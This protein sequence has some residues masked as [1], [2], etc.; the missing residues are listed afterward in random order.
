MFYF[1]LIQTATD[2]VQENFHLRLG[3]NE[4]IEYKRSCSVLAGLRKNTHIPLRELVIVSTDSELTIT[5]KLNEFP[6]HET[7]SKFVPSFWITSWL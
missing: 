7:S 5:D 6:T 1:R 3:N 2:H 4:L